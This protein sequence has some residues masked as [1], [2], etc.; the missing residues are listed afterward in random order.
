MLG[1]FRSLVLDAIVFA[2]APDAPNVIDFRAPVPATSP[3]TSRVARV[4]ARTGGEREAYATISKVT[5]EPG[6]VLLRRVAAE[7]SA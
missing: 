2:Y 6:K 7:L 4:L 3:A 5:F 1:E